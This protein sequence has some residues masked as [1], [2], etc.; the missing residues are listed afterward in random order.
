MACPLGLGVWFVFRV[1]EVPGS[2]PR[3]D[4]YPFA[5]IWSCVKQSIL[6]YLTWLH[7][8]SGSFFFKQSGISLL[9]IAAIAVLHY[10]SHNPPNMHWSAYSYPI[11]I[12]RPSNIGPMRLRVWVPI[13]SAVEPTK[14]SQ[15]WAI[16]RCHWRIVPAFIQKYQRTQQTPV[17]PAVEPTQRHA[18]HCHHT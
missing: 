6:L 13:Q 1:D 2:I 16:V 8:L 14:L 9:I 7:I 11:H 4:L 10:F 12:W 3:V 18:H 5:R 15:P 17:R